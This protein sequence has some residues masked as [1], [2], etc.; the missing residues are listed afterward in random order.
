MLL[1]HDVAADGNCF[2]SSVAAQLELDTFYCSAEDKQNFNMDPTVLAVRPNN[3]AR[4]QSQVRKLVSSVMKQP[5][6][7]RQKLLVAAAKEKWEAT[8]GGLIDDHPELQSRMPT[9]GKPTNSMTFDALAD[10]VAADK[11]W[12]S[13]N[14]IAILQQFLQ[15][16][17]WYAQC[18]NKEGIVSPWT[19]VCQTFDGSESQTMPGT[20]RRAMYMRRTAYHCNGNQEHS[21]HFGS[22]E[23]AATV[24]PWAA[25]LGA[26]STTNGKKRK[27]NDPLQLAR[28][29]QDAEDKEKA[30]AMA[31]DRDFASD[32]Q[33]LINNEEAKA[34]A[35][36]KGPAAEAPR[37]TRSTKRAASNQVEAQ[38]SQ[39]CKLTNK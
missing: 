37:T 38:D 10:S 17:L 32:Y 23:P 15:A 24:A 33:T 7:D 31:R 9:R 3:G 30:S 4:T 26:D 34:A 11:V 12:A 39:R 35:E 36:V 6:G 28:E 14:I 25:Q 29:L 19:W 27:A 20:K 1:Y 8:K 18:L 13:P 22:L 5:R 21:E 2:F 16:D